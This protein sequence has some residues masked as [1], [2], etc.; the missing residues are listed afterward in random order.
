MKT[1][2]SIPKK[3][4]GKKTARRVHVFDKLDGSNLRFEWC[5][6][7]GWHRWGARRK[8]I[9]E[10]HVILGSAM[11]LFETN[12]ADHIE[13]RAVD[14]GWQCLVAFAEFHGSNSLAGQH[15]ASD[16]KELSLFDVAPAR[17]GLL[18]PER[19]LERFGDL[20]I[21]PYLGEFDWDDEFVAK[22]RRNELAGVSFEGVIG[23]A[24]CGHSLVMAKAKTQAWV[25]RILEKHGEKKG[26]KLVNS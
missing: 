10:S 17:R 8:V 5:H 19:F 9:D 13:K 26:R 16:R 3:F 11:Q 18:G 6:K 14:E 21:A 23:K 4:K 7:R 2:P 24:G 1:Y 12:F 20:A 15:F 22:I 25:D